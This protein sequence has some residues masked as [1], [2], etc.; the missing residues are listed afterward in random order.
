MKMSAGGYPRL[1]S[2]CISSCPLASDH[3][4]P[5]ADLY[6]QT[7][8]KAKEGIVML[9]QSGYAIYYKFAVPRRGR[10]VAEGYSLSRK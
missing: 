8:K 2:S 1:G 10:S 3:G 4:P 6:P 5:F 9:N 7:S